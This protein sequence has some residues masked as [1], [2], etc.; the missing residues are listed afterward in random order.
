MGN[1]VLRLFLAAW[2][3]VVPNA[4]TFL[5]GRRMG[6]DVSIL[7]YQALAV[8]DIR[9]AEYSG[10]PPGHCTHWHDCEKQ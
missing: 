5:A 9:A 6:V 8:E 1:K 7:A 2:S 4:P 10:T 3:V